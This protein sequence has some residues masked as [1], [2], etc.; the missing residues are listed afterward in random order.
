MGFV[1][2]EIQHPDYK[3][4]PKMLTIWG[5]SMEIYEPI[6]SSFLSS[7]LGIFKFKFFFLHSSYY[8]PPILP[9]ESSSSHFYSL[10]LQEDVPTPYVP[11]QH[12]IPPPPSGLKSLKVRCYFSYWGRNK[13]SSAMYE[14]GASFQLLY[15]CS[16]V[17]QCLRDLEDPG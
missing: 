6:S 15:T 5:Q 4:V 16:L 11:L 14:S 1:K 8:P 2:Q 12:A 9:S 3:H 17:A 10:S 13:Q 7:F